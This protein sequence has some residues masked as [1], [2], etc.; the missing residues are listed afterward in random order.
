MS[1]TPT[2]SWSDLDSKGFVVVRGLVP[3]ATLASLREDFSTGLPPESY[4]FSFKLLGHGALEDA[5]GAMRRALEPL[6]AATKT[7]ADILERVMSH[8][9]TT[10]LG[11]GP[12]SVWHQDFDFDYMLTKDH[13]NYLI[14]WL[15][16]QKPD[17]AKSNLRVLPWDSLEAADAEAYRRLVGAGGHRLVPKDGVTEVHGA[18]YG[19]R[20][21][22][23]AFAIGA[24]IESIAVTP[25]LDA[26]DA[27][28]LRGDVVHRTQDIETKRVAASVRATFSGKKISRRL[29]GPRPAPGATRTDTKAWVGTLLHGCFDKTTGPEI[30]MGELM[31]Y[32]A[33]LG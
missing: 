11:P 28:I 1:A 2:A 29:A 20:V 13:L 17:R 6:R 14:F 18:A 30:T 19:K 23:P 33:T 4:P 10:A 12:A 26:G 3:E 27:L 31:E 21:G 32:A 5:W 15:P 9:V 24:D 8:Y 22:P 7:R 25:E 16:I